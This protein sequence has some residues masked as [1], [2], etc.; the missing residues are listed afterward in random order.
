MYVN[1]VCLQG[2]REVTESSG[3]KSAHDKLLH[4]GNKCGTVL[5]FL[6]GS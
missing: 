5:G 1:W 3:V 4:L 2:L 6:F